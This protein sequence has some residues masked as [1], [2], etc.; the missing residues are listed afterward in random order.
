MSPARSAA[1]H[2]IPTSSI[3]PEGS[4]G[5]TTSCGS[6]PILLAAFLR[7]TPVRRG[8]RSRNRT[9]AQ[10]ARVMPAR[11]VA[12]HEHRARRPNA[13]IDEDHENIVLVPRKTRSRSPHLDTLQ[14]AP[15]EAHRLPAAHRAI[16][17]V[18]D[19]RG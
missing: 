11:R 13:L 1:P 5:A 14:R 12:L 18:T 2:G 10:A 19:N 8:K 7:Q 3:G 16:R 15:G 6:Y 17:R 4:I 9:E